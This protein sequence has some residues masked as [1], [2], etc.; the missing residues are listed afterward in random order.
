[1]QWFGNGRCEQRDGC[2][3]V[4]LRSVYFVHFGIFV[5]WDASLLYLDVDFCNGRQ[6]GFFYRAALHFIIVWFFRLV[7][8]TRIAFGFGVHFPAAMSLV[9]FGFRTVQGNRFSFAMHFVAAG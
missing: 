4:I 2:F 3:R 1:M 8:A 6:H 7:A 5:Q 9:G